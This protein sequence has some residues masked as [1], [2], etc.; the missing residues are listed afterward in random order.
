MTVETASFISQLDATLPASGD[1]KSEGDN[2]LRLVKSVLK[3]QFPNFGTNA[4][5]PTAAEVNYLGGVT[6]AIQT[7]ID[8]KGA[9]AGQTWTGSHNFT[10]ASVTVPTLSPGASGNG[11][12]SVDFVNALSF[13]SALPAQAGNAGKFVTTNGTAASWTDALVA[14]SLNGGQFAG[15]RRRNFNGNFDV[16][17]RAVTGTV[18][19]AAGAYGHDGWKAGSSGCTYTFATANG[20]TTL[21]ISAGSLQQVIEGALLGSGTYCLSWTGTAQGKIAAGAYSA[22]GVT[23]SATGGANLTIEFN[24]GTLSL[25]QLE[26]G[27][28][29]TPFEWRP[30]TVELLIAQRYFRRVGYLPS[31]AASLG[32]GRCVSTTT[33]YVPLVFVYPMRALPAVTVSSGTGFSVTSANNTLITST[34]LSANLTSAV[35]M[36]LFVTVASGLVAGDAFELLVTAGNFVDLDAGL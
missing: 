12:A 30:A 22:S 8:G 17:Q 34:A 1:P 19:L 32:V 35:S 26:L 2:H 20:V 18:T 33:G 10:G 16:N 4:V 28:L 6:S 13:A 31:A 9:I 7:Q 25:V 29:P 14:T 23:A 36:Q 15:M 11:A 21:T 3:G 27:T 24:T 5:T